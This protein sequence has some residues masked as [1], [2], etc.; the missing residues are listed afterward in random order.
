MVVRLLLLRAFLVLYPAAGPRGD[1]RR[2]RPE[3]DTLSVHRDLRHDAVR[4][5][6]F[7]LGRVPLPAANLSP[8]GLPVLHLEHPDLLGGVLP[9]AR[10]G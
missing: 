4:D 8:L 6:N 2:Q 3:H 10:R 7:R 5:V 9:D 1:G